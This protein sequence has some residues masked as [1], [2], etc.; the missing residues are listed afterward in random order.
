MSA[1]A[2]QGKLSKIAFQVWPPSTV[3]HNPPDE[4]PR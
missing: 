2:N 3:F 4:N 1:M